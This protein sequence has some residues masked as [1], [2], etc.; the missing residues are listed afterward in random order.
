MTIIRY[1]IK[2]ISKLSVGTK[3]TKRKIEEFP[4][5]VLL[6]IALLAAL[7][8]TVAYSCE[9]DNARSSSE[10]ETGVWGV[11]NGRT[12]PSRN[13][14]G[15]CSAYTHGIWPRGMGAR[16]DGVMVGGCSWDDLFFGE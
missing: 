5:I 9:V 12:P 14:R 3:P 10:I 4:T 7:L 8:V 16:E 1:N 6:I 2:H 15:R 11:A 13:A